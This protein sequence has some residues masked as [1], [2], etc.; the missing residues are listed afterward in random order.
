MNM[1]MEIEKE[2]T[3]EYLVLSVPAGTNE[4]YQASFGLWVVLAEIYGDEAVDFSPSVSGSMK[5]PTGN[6]IV[7]VT[8]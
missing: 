3:E 4:A 8:L 2:G 1:N 5:N 6:H 7:T